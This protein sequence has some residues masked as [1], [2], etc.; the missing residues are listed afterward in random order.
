MGCRRFN[1]C[2]SEIGNDTVTQIATLAA[3]MPFGRPGALQQG[4]RNT[5]RDAAQVTEKSHLIPENDVLDR[6]DTRAHLAQEYANVS[7]SIAD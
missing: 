6:I 5:E 3:L 7:S 2:R 4:D 1:G